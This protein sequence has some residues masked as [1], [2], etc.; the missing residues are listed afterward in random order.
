MYHFIRH[1]NREWIKSY[2]S[3]KMEELLMFMSKLPVLHKQKSK[4]KKKSRMLYKLTPSP[5]SIKAD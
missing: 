2:E 3:N 5:V 4:T 1:A